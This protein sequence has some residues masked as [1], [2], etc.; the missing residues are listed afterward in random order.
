MDE[1]SKSGL[2]N[3][4]DSNSLNSTKCAAGLSLTEQGNNGLMQKIS[5]EL[6]ISG[7]SKK[8]I[9]TYS[10]II[11]AFLT[12]LNSINKPI[13]TI[14]KDEIVAFFAKKKQGIEEKKQTSSNSTMCLYYSALKFLLKSIKK[15]EL[16]LEL[17]FPRKSKKLPAVLTKKEIKK[18]LENA[19]PMRNKIIV[20][21]LYSTGVRV[22][23]AVKLK[24]ENINFDEGTAIVKSGKGNKDR[25]VILSKK[26]GFK[27]KKHI[28][29]RKNQSDFLFAHK[30]GKPFSVDTIQK[31][32]KT[33]AEQANI[34]KKVTPHTLRHSFATHLLENGENIRKIQELLGHSNLATTQ[35]YT[36]VF[37]EELKKVISP[38]DSLTKK[39]TPLSNS[40]N[41]Q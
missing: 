3:S 35:I 38:L 4:S 25:L 2:E 5:N 41:K 37:P 6:T 29:N 32:V 20:E 40:D 1:T 36:K 11:K 23:E 9:E 18:L 22:S 24:I 16:I 34:T 21:F 19:K 13:E 27:M 14:S 17:G 28:E 26:W 7:Y 30:N 10:R 33:S 39:N 15:T 31:I 8:T 12:Y